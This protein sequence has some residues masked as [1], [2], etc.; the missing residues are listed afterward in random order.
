[1][2]FTAE[3]QH[4]SD[5]TVR[6]ILRGE[7]DVAARDVLRRVLEAERR[8]RTPVLVVLDQ[9]DFLDSSGI[10]E[11]LDARRQALAEGVRFAVTPGTGHVRHVLWASGVLAHLCGGREGPDARL[12]LH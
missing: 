4:E 10:A 5:G 8:A 2:D 6:L 12:A 11:L 3:R 1:M 7:I 9:L